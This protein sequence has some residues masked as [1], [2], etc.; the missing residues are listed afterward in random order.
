MACRANKP[1]VP[2]L[3]ALDVARQPSIPVLTFHWPDAN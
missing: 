3:G 1:W 2:F